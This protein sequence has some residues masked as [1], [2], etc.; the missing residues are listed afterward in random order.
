MRL[1]SAVTALVDAGVDAISVVDPSLR[2]LHFNRTYARLTGLRPREL[3]EAER[4]AMCHEHF[5]LASCADGQCA[6]LRALKLGKPLRI[7]EV[8]AKNGAARWIVTAIPLE[9]AS[10]AHYAVVEIYRDVTAESRMQASYHEL[11]DRERRRNEV[12]QEEVRKRTQELEQHVEALR[13]TRSQ[14]IQSEKM[15]SL[16]R[17]VAGIAHELNNPINFIYGNVD[18]L[19]RHAEK[20]IGLVNEAAE[21]LRAGAAP[22]ALDAALSRARFP[23]ITTDLRKVLPAVRAGAE[24][25]VRI[26][27]GLRTFSHI[28]TGEFVET[29]L[30]REV[31]LALQLVRN[32]ERDRIEIS[33]DLQKLPTVRCNGA[34]I[35]QVVT[36]LIVNAIDSISGHG[37]VRVRT[38]AIDRG[39]VAI[40][41][42]DDGCGMDE[43]TLGKIFEPFFTTKDVGRGTGLGLSISYGIVQAHHGK[44]EVESAPGRGTTFRI[45]LPVGGSPS[46]ELASRRAGSERPGA[47]TP[48]SAPPPHLSGEVKA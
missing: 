22:A 2:L 10:G 18:F 23:F 47:G 17:L 48:A 19:E 25:S 7:D 35:G 24:R 36:N 44:L 5:G 20:L 30:N 40:E 43:E 37:T 11:L 41:V 27:Q 3:R 32:H 21:L 46:P 31:E 12:L 16:G 9:D 4:I 28:G 45:V 13:V 34:Q 29:D 15:S 6:S 42:E 26:I 33:V 8:A 38:K 39:S 14:L 1:P